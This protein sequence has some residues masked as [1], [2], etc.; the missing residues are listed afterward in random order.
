MTK[1][2]KKELH[3]KRL[4]FF[5]MY[6]SI[7]LVDEEHLLLSLIG[8]T[9]RGT[10]IADRAYREL[11]AWSSGFGLNLRIS[12]QRNIQLIVVALGVAILVGGHQRTLRYVQL[13]TI[14]GDDD[15]WHFWRDDP[16]CTLRE[17]DAVTVEESLRTLWLLLATTTPLTLLRSLYVL[18][19]SNE[20]NGM[21]ASE[22]F[23]SRNACSEDG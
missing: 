7:C 4:Q 2:L 11:H 3:P 19:I 18:T 17:T 9:H 1:V 21:C 23:N 20:V 15:L 12:L 5:F 8:G 22:T 13:L 10:T 6:E 14:D 16:L